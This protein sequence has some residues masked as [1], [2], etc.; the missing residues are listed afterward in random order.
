MPLDN[1]MIV[2]DSGANGPALKSCSLTVGNQTYSGSVLGSAFEI[3]LTEDI[4]QKIGIN[5]GQKGIVLVESVDGQIQTKEI[6]IVLKNLS[7]SNRLGLTFNT[8]AAAINVFKIPS[9]TKKILRKVSDNSK[10]L[11][12]VVGTFETEAPTQWTDYTVEGGKKYSYCAVDENNEAIAMET[13]DFET[14]FYHLYLADNNLMISIRFNPATSGLKYV[15]QEAITNTLGG[16]YPVIR[17]NGETKYKQFNIAGLLYLDYYTNETFICS[18]LSDQVETTE[19]VFGLENESCLYM[20]E[21]STVSE[22]LAELSQRAAEKELRKIAEDFLLNEKV[23]IFRSYE[24][25]PMFVYLSNI[26]FSPNKQLND[27]IYEFSAQ[28]TEI[29]EFNSDNLA[30]YGFTSLN[31]S[32]FYVDKVLD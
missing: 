1:L 17:K 8:A 6:D 9:D 22:R 14:D 5:E 7:A 4:L 24:E 32:H 18:R 31:L 23:K 16:K 26:S 12:T 2:G 29:C 3:K 25:G 13:T 10:K 27:H 20:T 15:T 19:Q 28:A 21:N 30:R 11:W